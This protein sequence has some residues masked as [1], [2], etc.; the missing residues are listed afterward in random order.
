MFG[1]LLGALSS[2]GAPEKTAKRRA[3]IEKR[4]AEKLRQLEE[5]FSQRERE[6][7]EVLTRI[8]RKEQWVVDDAAVSK[9]GSAFRLDC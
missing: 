6:Q 3:D 9:S 7:A 8:R 4:Q 1:V 5:D 2:S